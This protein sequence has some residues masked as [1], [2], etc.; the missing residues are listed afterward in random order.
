L[1]LVACLLGLM[2]Y[3]AQQS[4]ERRAA[5]REAE[6]TADVLSSYKLLNQA[7][8]EG[9]LEILRSVLSGSN[10]Q[11][12]QEQQTMLLNQQLFERP[13]P[14]W[15]HL[16]QD[17]TSIQVDPTFNEVQLTITQ[18]YQIDNNLPISQA[19]LAQTIIFRPGEFSWLYTDPTDEFWGTE[20]RLIG[21]HITIIYPARDDDYVTE[22]ASYLDQLVGRY[23][24][25]L[26]RCGRSPKITITLS[27]EAHSIPILFNPTEAD[28]G[29][30]K[31]LELPT[32]SL[33]GRPLDKSSAQA[34]YGTYGVFVVSALNQRFI[35]RDR[36]GQEPFDRVLLDQ[37]LA[38]LNLPQ[39]YLT[40][41]AP[42]EP[43]FLANLRDYH[44]LWLISNLPADSPIIGRVKQLVDFIKLIN[45]QTSPLELQQQIHEQSQSFEEWFIAITN[46]TLSNAE[47]AWLKHVHEQS[48]LDRL[49]P[50]DAYTA[51]VIGLLCTNTDDIAN[52]V[53]L[54]HINDPQWSSGS[55][56]GNVLD[57][58]FNHRALPDDNGFIIEQRPRVRDGQ[59]YTLLVRDNGELFYTFDEETL[60][61][62]LEYTGIF[63][64]DQNRLL[65]SA[66]NP[67]FG[68]TEFHILD[69][70]QCTNDQCP[71]TLSDGLPIWSP[72]GEHTLLITFQGLH[73]GTPNGQR[74]QRIGRGENPFWV[75]ADTFGYLRS[76]GFENHNGVLI[77]KNGLVLADVGQEE[78]K[79]TITAASFEPI[80][81][82]VSE[83]SADELVFSIEYVTANQTNGRLYIVGSTLERDYFYLLEHN[84]A[85]GRSRL[86]LTL[87]QLPGR[88]T[89]SPDGR[90]LALTAFPR[91]V[92]NA[93]ETNYGHEEAQLY[94]LNLRTNKKLTYTFQRSMIASRSNWLPDWSADGRW[95]IMND[96][97]SLHI[98]A[99]EAGYQQRVFHTFVTCQDAAWL[100]R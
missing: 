81:A 93:L 21:E 24:L 42:E 69:L 54:N 83:E 19:Q 76:L 67:E 97:I 84:L 2:G 99:P 41:A 7:V 58:Q 40:T 57:Y 37:Q 71:L 64:S 10:T 63:A 100:N 53:T 28:V 20:Q 62:P 51:Q 74:I 77:S 11:W 31:L 18:T 43:L 86:L 55:S 17:D 95:F 27:R 14:G 52:Y 32:P 75:D 16:S 72:D 92:G 22:L 50:L 56:L 82:A 87:N 9:D 91:E 38:Q 59:W 78:E 48:N 36:L 33:I 12:S 25:M 96:E 39:Q 30:V 5:A 66:P 49:P 44:D 98:I 34:L 13:F 47:R 89:F 46:S 88:L 6:I 8:D 3:T 85:S 60:H 29:P 79:Q 26:R 68:F 23:C 35:V 61:T 65:M 4:L 80:I 94:L 45:P 15:R 1:F 90:W 73:L 70:N